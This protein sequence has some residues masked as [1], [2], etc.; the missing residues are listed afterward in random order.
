MHHDASPR[1]LRV[2]SM[3]WGT[4]TWALA[5]MAALGAVE[6]ID[7]MVFA[8]AGHERV[9]TYRFREQQLRWLRRRGVRETR[10]EPDRPHYVY[11]GDST[12]VIIPAFSKHPVTGRKGQL[13]RH[14]T[15][16]WKSA[17]V[18]KQLHRE[19]AQR[20]RPLEP[21]CVELWLG[22][23]ADE[24]RRA[25]P[26]DVRYIRH[27][28]PLIEQGFTRHDS[29]RWLR[30]HGLPLAPRSSCYFCPLQDYESWRRMKREGGPDWQRAVHVDAELREARIEN[31][32]QLFL[33]PELKPLPEAVRIPEDVGHHALSLLET[34]EVS[35]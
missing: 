7:L 17:P 9:E 18:R 19:L 13:H 10:V 11:Y 29:F 15:P 28:Y 34:E 12:R 24:A 25:V 30:Q 2:L 20:G 16:A 14:C 22:I 4:Q 27:R 26:A 23:S 31:G 5:A 32:A 33:H 6:P 8:D 21:E 3:G 35:T 1:P